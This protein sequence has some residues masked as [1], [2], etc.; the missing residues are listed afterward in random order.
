LF[1]VVFPLLFFVIPKQPVWHQEKEENKKK[2]SSQYF[3]LSSEDI[4]SRI[5]IILNFSSIAQE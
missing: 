3:C 1:S 5:F 2:F 4:A